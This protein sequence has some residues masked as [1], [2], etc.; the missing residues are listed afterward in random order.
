M[1]R[2][3][4][5]QMRARQARGRAC[6]AQPKWHQVAGYSR[7]PSKQAPHC[8]QPALPQCSRA[9]HSWRKMRTTSCTHAA[10]VCRQRAVCCRCDAHRVPGQPRIAPGG[11]RAST[12]AY[13]SFSGRVSLRQKHPTLARLGPVQSHRAARLA[14]YPHHTWGVWRR[15]VDCM[16]CCSILPQGFDS[17]R[18]VRIESTLGGE[19]L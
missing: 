5:R 1:H 8:G 14:E 4:L 13:A 2:F 11:R 9:P 18:V 7:A 19:L 15:T 12:P 6:T 16:F 3:R 10:G 17:P